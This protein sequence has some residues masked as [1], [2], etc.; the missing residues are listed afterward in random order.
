MKK[1]KVTSKSTEIQKKR[2]KKRLYNR[3]HNIMLTDQDENNAVCFF[4]DNRI[5]TRPIVT[6]KGIDEIAKQILGI[7]RNMNLQVIKDD[8]LINE[9][10]YKVEVNK[11]IKEEF[12]KSLSEILYLSTLNKRDLKTRLDNTK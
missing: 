5:H 6:I 8:I 10:Y 1:I 4:Y 11:E 7:A 12:Y 9:I 2:H 3:K